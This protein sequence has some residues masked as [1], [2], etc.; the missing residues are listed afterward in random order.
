M[1]QSG[2][3]NRVAEV[4]KSKIGERI[5]VT[6]TN[7]KIYYRVDAQPNLCFVLQL[8]DE[9]GEIRRLDTTL[10][11]L[12]ELNNYFLYFGIALSLFGFGSLPFKK[13]NQARKP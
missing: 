4:L 5:E 10:D 7:K 13:G 2:D 9:Q 1:K 11:Y 12:E 8:S 6:C 3:S